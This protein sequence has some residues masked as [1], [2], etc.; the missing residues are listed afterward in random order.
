MVNCAHPVHFSAAHHAALRSRL[1]S[2]AVLGGRC[3]TD[4]RHVAVICSGWAGD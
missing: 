4:A 2:V 3:G 1:P